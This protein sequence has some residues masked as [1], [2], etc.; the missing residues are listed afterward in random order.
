MVY[1]LIIAGSGSV[2]AATGYYASRAGLKVLMIDAKHPP[3]SFGAHS[4]LRRLPLPYSQHSPARQALA[5]RSQQ[6]WQEFATRHVEYLTIVSGTAYS[7]RNIPH[8]SIKTSVIM[9]ILQHNRT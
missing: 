3:H 1:D 9:I 6:Q 2:G 8:R 4:G 5:A 7:I